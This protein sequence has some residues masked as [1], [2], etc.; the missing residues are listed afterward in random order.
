MRFPHTSDFQPSLPKRSKS[1]ESAIELFVL[2][3]FRT[4]YLDEG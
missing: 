1:I 4:L 2:F 3:F